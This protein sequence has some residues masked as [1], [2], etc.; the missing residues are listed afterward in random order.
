MEYWLVIKG[1][2]HETVSELAKLLHILLQ[3]NQVV[4]N[5]DQ[6]KWNR[7]S[8]LEA[9]QLVTHVNRTLAELIQI[10]FQTC[11]VL[12]ENFQDQIT[13]QSQSFW[14]QLV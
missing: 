6:Q 13:Y 7:A 2:P 5:A 12:F 4:V 14:V 10:L 9:K 1:D 11:N 3:V 8:L